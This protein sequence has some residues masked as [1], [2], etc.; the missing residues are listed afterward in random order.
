MY[1]IISKQKEIQMHNH[2]DY[3]AEFEPVTVYLGLGSN[4]GD[5]WQNLKSAIN[6]LSRKVDMTVFSP[7]Y[8]TVPIG[9]IEQ[10]RF[11]NMACEAVSM[12]TPIELLAIVKQIEREI[13]RQPGSPNS[14]RPIDIDILF[15]SD[16]LINTAELIIPHPRLVERAFVLVPLADIAP[17]FIHPVTGQSIFQ[18]LKALQRN[19]DDVVRWENV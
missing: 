10:P 3:L 19:S 5:R 14:P 12:L 18:M 7:I 17:D 8:D 16:Q 4:M 1:V 9:N 13:G 11:L 6:L 2:S 15:Y